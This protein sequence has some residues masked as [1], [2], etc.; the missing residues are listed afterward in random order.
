MLTDLPYSFVHLLIL[1]IIPVQKIIINFKLNQF[2]NLN[3]N[4]NFIYKIFQIMEQNILP[5]TRKNNHKTTIS[6]WS[7]SVLIVLLF[8]MLFQ[9]ADSQPSMS[10]APV[11]TTIN[12]NTTYQITIVNGNLNTTTN[13]TAVIEITF[14]SNFFTLNTSQ[15]YTCFNTNTPSQTYPCHA[16]TTNVIQ[17]SNPNIT[18]LVGQISVS[19]IKNPGSQEQV[20]FSYVF[21]YSNGTIISQATSSL[22]RSYTPGN[23]QSCSVNFNPS[24]VQSTSTVTI[25]MA[26]GDQIPTNGS[27]YITFPSSWTYSANSSSTPVITSLTQTCTLISGGAYLTSA[28]GC[29]TFGQQ[30]TINQC[31]STTAPNGTSLSFSISNI[32]SPPTNYNG[33]TITVSTYTDSYTLIDQTSCTANQVGPTSI[34]GISSTTQLT[35]GTTSSYALNF[36]APV[37]IAG[38]DLLMI[39][40]VSPYD[41]YFSFGSTTTVYLSTAQQLAISTSNSS[42]ITL[43]F[44]STMS[45]FSTGTNISIIAGLYIQPLINSGAKS[46]TITLLRSGYSYATQSFPLTILPNSLVTPTITLNTYMV[47]TVATYTFNVGLTNPLATKSRIIITLPNQLSIANG[48]CTS[49]L[50][51]LNNPSSINSSSTCNVTSNR[52]ITLTSINTNTLQSG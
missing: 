36:N 15:T 8:C 25:T 5:F 20:T 44:P 1:L 18:S 21:K 35:V 14:P 30:I 40:A 34:P 27:I 43:V 32:L 6:I 28:L 49:T 23:L 17:I 19:T 37:P 4:F 9:T 48:I 16:S 52:V 42:S 46:L 2:I 24:S 41:T 22:F 12:A 51:A 11:V 39:S 10:A 38:S 13:S 26:L 7:Q 33:Y 29:S 45:T 50:S 47:S 3:S 31:F